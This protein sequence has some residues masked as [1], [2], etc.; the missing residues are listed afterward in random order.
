MAKKS[1]K[2]A[3]KAKAKK[4]A[5]KGRKPAGELKDEQV[6]GA[7]GGAFNAYLQFGDIQGEST[8]STH[9]PILYAKLP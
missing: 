3:P 7:A 4:A 6:E 1:K 2:A 8:D 5:P 9:T